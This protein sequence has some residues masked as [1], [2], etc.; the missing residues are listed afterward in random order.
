MNYPNRFKQYLHERFNLGQFV[1]LSLLLCLIFWASSQLYLY[2]Q[3]KEF[4]PLVYSS[5]AL[6]L[7]FFKLRL[8]DEFKDYTHDKK[9]HPER[10]VSRGLVKLD[11]LKP[12]IIICLFLEILIAI[13]FTKSSFFIYGI[14]LIYS[15]LMYKE[16]FCAEKLRKNFTLYI[17]LHEIVIIPLSMYLL[18]INKIPVNAI[19]NQH[20]ILIII[21]VATQLFLLEVARK[22]RSKDQETAGNDTYTSQYGT[23]KASILLS[24][25]S[26]IIVAVIAGGLSRQGLFLTLVSV[27]G[28]N[29]IIG[30]FLLVPDRKN[31]KN[32]FAASVLFVFIIDIIYCTNLFK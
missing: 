25:L 26:I 32:V 17:L 13:I 31:A 9:F 15:F 5:L 20:F 28:H 14:V 16:F 1:F 2:H 3:I 11:E 22:I 4:S 7:F 10:P 24:V 21:F 6:F 27:I 8:L 23:K 29:Y 19:L 12:W 30:K 18:A